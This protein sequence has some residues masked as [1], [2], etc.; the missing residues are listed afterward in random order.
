MSPEVARLHSLGDATM[1]PSKEPATSAATGT[2]RPAGKPLSAK[3]LRAQL[4]MQPARNSHAPTV[5]V[6]IPQVASPAAPPT[7]SIL[8]KHAEIRWLMAKLAAA[9]P[10][11]WT[12]QALIE[13]AEVACRDADSALICLR[14]LVRQKEGR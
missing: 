11:R 13:D 7:P 3:E 1:Q 8:A 10:D 2:S 9:Q 14:D 6:A 4:A 5:V 12:A